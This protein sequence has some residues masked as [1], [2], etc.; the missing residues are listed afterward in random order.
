MMIAKAQGKD[1][2]VVFQEAGTDRPLDGDPERDLRSIAHL[3]LLQSLARKLNRLNDVTEIGEAIVDE[4]RMLVDYNN[5]IV[6]LLDGRAPAAG[7]RARAARDRRATS[8]SSSSSAR[9]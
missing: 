2:V 9:G 3:K 1:Q 6:Y 7:G 4:L 5:C 8:G